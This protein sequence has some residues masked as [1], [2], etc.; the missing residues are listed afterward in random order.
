MYKLLDKPLGR[1]MLFFLPSLNTTERL[2]LLLK[3]LL[4]GYLVMIRINFAQSAKKL[5]LWFPVRQLQV[6]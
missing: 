6:E 1:L 3:M 2:H 5:G 4:I